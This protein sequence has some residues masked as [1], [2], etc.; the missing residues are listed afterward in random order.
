M[1]DTR[2]DYGKEYKIEFFGVT[3][4]GFELHSE[5]TI[6]LPSKASEYIY[7]YYFYAIPNPE[8]ASIDLY[9]KPTERIA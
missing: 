8:D 2:L 3:Q 5:L 1:F 7:P 9:W 6:S 4:K